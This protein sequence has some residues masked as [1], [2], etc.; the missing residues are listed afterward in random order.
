[1]NPFNR[2]RKVYHAEA[3]R[4][5][6]RLNELRSL[7]ALPG[8]G[9]SEEMNR[10]QRRLD[11]LALQEPAGEVWGT[12]EAARHRDRPQSLDY[13]EHIFTDFVELHGDRLS[14][15]DPAIVGGLASVDDTPV[16]VIGQQK[17][18][19]FKER[20][21]R[22]FGM[23]GPDGYRK[24]QRLAVMAEKFKLPV[25]TLVDTPGAY[26][27]AA[28]ERKGQA[29]AIA[30]TL[31]TFARLK[32]CTVAVIIGEGGSG[33]ALALALCDRVYMLENSTY[34]VITPEGCAAILWRDVGQAGQA[35]E[36][37]KITAHDLLD[38]E[39]IDGVV[40]EP[41]RGAHKHHRAMARR[42]ERQIKRGLEEVRELT[43]EARVR[44]RRQKYLAMG[45]YSDSAVIS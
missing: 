14:G 20:Q 35:A 3:A 1:M 21:A 28:A 2:I 13:I 31:R 36:A 24:A 5:V 37:L 27:G 40:L 15:D 43:P 17:G 22:N 38:L 9:Y 16:V 25:V 39:V 26:P 29:A 42:V 18:R 19:D 10:I 7:P 34:S 23:S 11:V 45:R 6:K 4:L 33:G 8:I 44:E 32:V 12:V 30:S 41:R